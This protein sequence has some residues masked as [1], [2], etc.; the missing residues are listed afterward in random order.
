MG[1]PTALVR[2]FCAL[3]NLGRLHCLGAWLEAGV[4]NIGEENRHKRR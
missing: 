1:A 4:A 3:A 2:N